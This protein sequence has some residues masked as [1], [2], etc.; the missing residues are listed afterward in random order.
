MRTLGD[1][2][3][4]LNRGGPIHS[5]FL[6]ERNKMNKLVIALVAAFLTST[7]HA[8]PF[9]SSTATVVASVG[10]L[11]DGSF[12]YFW[13]ADRGDKIEQLISGT[14]LTSVNGLALDLAITHNSL[15]SNSFVNWDVYLNDVLVGDW[16]WASSNSIGA[17]NASY[18]FAS[19]SGN[20]DYLLSMRVSNE[21]VAGGGS[22]A[23]RQNGTATLRGANGVPEPASV[24][25]LG[26]GLVGLGAMRL[27]K[28]G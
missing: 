18:S 22:I 16:T 7:A 26:I 17:L 5:Y 14:G 24:A 13:S 8:I 12:G 9:P 2:I 20:G 28:Q 4:N 10:D 1:L 25:L 27:R 23:I 19:I 21:V 15:T 11:G 3:K 6:G